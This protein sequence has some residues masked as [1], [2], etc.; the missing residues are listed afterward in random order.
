MKKPINQL[1][2]NTIMKISDHKISKAEWKRFLSAVIAVVMAL[3]IFPQDGSAAETVEA[4]Y[5]GDTSAVAILNNLDYSDVRSSNTWAKEAIYETGALEIIKGMKNMSKRFGRT[6][7]LSKQEALAI[8]YKAAGRE[9]EA[10]TLGENMNA[11]RALANRKTDPLEV[12]YDG[13]LQLAANDGLITAGNLADAL[14]ADQTTLTAGSFYRTGAVQRQE[15][16]RWLAGTL[17]IQPVRGQ[18]D[19]F[20]NYIDWRS[21]DPDKIPYI[22]AILENRIMNGDGTG[23]FR[24]LQ[25]VT[26]EQAAQI[27]KNAEAQVLAALKYNKQTG[28]IEKIS[29]AADY[30][31]GV[32][33]EGRYI[34]V[35]N[36]DGKLYRIETKLTAPAALNEQKGVTPAVTGKEIKITNIRK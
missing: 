22:E 31:G 29:T 26:R 16:A 6:D 28:I 8:A 30:S 2:L 33:S 4:V 17:G 7:T 18:Q 19:L 15:I 35:R 10:Q 20:N 12:W 27:V 14:T 5:P 32:S 3:S 25:A 11:A 13:Y 1:F 23:R 36:S 24:P 21:A 34:N 9:A